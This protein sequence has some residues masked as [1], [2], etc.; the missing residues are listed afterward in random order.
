MN[1][2]I[3]LDGR[4]WTIR[5]DGLYVPNVEYNISLNSGWGAKG[6]FENKAFLLREVDKDL[7]TVLAVSIDERSRGALWHAEDVEKAAGYKIM[8]FIGSILDG[9]GGFELCCSER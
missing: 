1:N 7:Y 8:V 4:E 3:L 9:I 6:E 5:D 2:N